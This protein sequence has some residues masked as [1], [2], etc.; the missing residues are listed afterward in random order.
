MEKSSCPICF[1]D[2]L[3]SDNGA[4]ANGAS[5]KG[6]SANGASANGASDN[7][8]SANG[9]S[10]N[11][12]KCK[13]SSKNLKKI[14]QSKITLDWSS[15]HHDCL[16]DWIMTKDKKSYYSPANC[17]KLFCPYCRKKFNYVPLPKN[18]FPIRYIH[19]EYNIIQ[20]FIDSKDEVSLNEVCPKLFNQ[21]YCNTILKTGKNCGYQCSRQKINGSSMCK[22][23]T[24]KYK[25][26]A[27]GFL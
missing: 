21:N 22:L 20:T 2:F 6:S 11:V 15:F 3:D 24:Q 9:A 23:H 4:S 12:D 10:A 8:A 26:I 5:A 19:Q 17:Y 16:V 14:S 13:F 7:G 18:M 27:Q 25:S 1:D